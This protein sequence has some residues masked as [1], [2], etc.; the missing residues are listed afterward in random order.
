MIKNYTQ[1]S[2]ERS[3]S[4]ILKCLELIQNKEAEERETKHRWD[5]EEISIVGESYV[6]NVML[7]TEP[8]ALKMPSR[9]FITELHLSPGGRF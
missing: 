1:K 6:S 2:Q 7:G 5:K 9:C 8:G 4:A 3:Y